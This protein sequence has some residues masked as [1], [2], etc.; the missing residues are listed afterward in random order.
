M[1]RVIID[2]TYPMGMD[3]IVSHNRMDDIGLYY[4]TRNFGG[5]VSDLYIGKTTYSYGSRLWHH[6]MNWLDDYRGTKQVRLGYIISPKNV[7][8]ENLRALINDAEET[9]IWLMRHS[10]IHNQKCMKDCYPKNRLYIT[11]IGYRGNL[12]AEM[13][14]SDEEWYG[15]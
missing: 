3:N 6:Y 4:I 5:N 2:W 9:I 15:V 7:S 8:K 12:P 10:L 11:N 14:F 1:K 13:C